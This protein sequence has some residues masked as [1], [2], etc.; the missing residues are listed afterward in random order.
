[1][2][3]FL[4]VCVRNQMFTLQMADGDVCVCVLLHLL[5]LVCLTLSELE[6]GQYHHK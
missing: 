1:M 4:E 6:V 2:E 3:G 5:S